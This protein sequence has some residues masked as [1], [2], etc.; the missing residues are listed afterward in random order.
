M[1]A[2]CLILMDGP[3]LQYPYRKKCTMLT[4]RPDSEFKARNNIFSFAFLSLT[5]RDLPFFLF[6]FFCRAGS[7]CR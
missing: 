6:L 7:S 2:T 5:S 1:V 4:G 3:A